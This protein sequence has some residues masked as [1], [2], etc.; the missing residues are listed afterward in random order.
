MSA[1]D[2]LNLSIDQSVTLRPRQIFCLRSGVQ[3]THS[4]I[5]DLTRPLLSKYHEDITPELHE[6][7]QIYLRANPVLNPLWQLIGVQKFINASLAVSEPSSPTIELARVRSQLLSFGTVHIRFPP[8]SPHSSHEI[9][10]RPISYMSRAQSFVQDSV[11]Y[12]WEISTTA[13]TS[14]TTAK[15]LHLFKAVAGKKFEIARYSTEDGKFGLG[16]L[17]VFDDTE[18]DSLVVSLTLIGVLTQNDSFFAP[19]LDLAKN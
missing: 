3:T 7:A 19:G 14:V 11:P 2:I 13:A 4:E 9:I 6:V 15:K 16:G 5:I 12:S 18:I 17:L 1:K 10:V 8:G